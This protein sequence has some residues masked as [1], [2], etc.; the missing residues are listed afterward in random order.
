MSA[1][2]RVERVVASDERGSD[3]LKKAKEDLKEGMKI[4]SRR[5]KMIKFADR[6]EAGWAVVEE[7]EDD[8]LASNSEDERRMEK[9]ERAA[10]KKVAKKRKLRERSTKED[11]VRKG[12]ARPDLSP[13]MAFAPAKPPTVP[14]MM[15]SM[16][17][18]SSGTCFHC[19]ELGHF[20]RECPTALASVP[21]PLPNVSEHM[22][23]ESMCCRGEVMGNVTHSGGECD[24]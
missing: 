21:Y 22:A 15:G 17:P 10:E 7:Y 9:A 2:T 24:T 12:A 6:S 8:A 5:Q 19:G 18:R 13:A 1:A 23:G 16:A 4:L 3:L 20:R 11:A 14:R